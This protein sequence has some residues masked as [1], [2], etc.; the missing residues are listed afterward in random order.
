MPR[1]PRIYLPGIP[2]HVVQRGN[3]CN[4]C[5]FEE[6]N[7]LFFLECLEEAGERYDVAIHAYVLMTNHIHLL[8]TPKTESGISRVMQLLGNRY[9]QYINKKY[10]KTGTLWEGRHKASLVDAEQYLLTCY[11]Y[12]EMNPV[13]ANM[14]NHPSD[15]RWSSYHCHATGS[16]SSTI[17]DHEVFL[18]I[19]PTPDERMHHYRELFRTALDDR[20]VHEVRKAVAFSVPL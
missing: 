4:A 20:D 13:R 9:V 8:M 5:F 11:R 3:D 6:E 2:S 17:K 12:I 1:K 16:P 15:Y 7:Y 19:A 10:R 14:V 18:R